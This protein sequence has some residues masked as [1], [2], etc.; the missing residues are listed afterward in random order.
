MS[1]TT[2]LNSGLSS[3]LKTGISQIL[4]NPQ[5][6]AVPELL[7]PY[8]S[9]PQKKLEEELAKIDSRFDLY[10]TNA[11]NLPKSVDY[12]ELSYTPLTDDEIKKYAE[13]ALKEYR[14]SGASQIND[15]AA[16]SRADLTSSKAGLSDA[17]L[18]KQQE[19]D[20]AYD[21]A[22]QS[23]SSDALKRGLARSSIIVNKLNALE[24]S[25]AGAKADAAES[26]IDGLY[27]IDQKIADLETERLD[28][29][30]EFDVLYA[31]KLSTEIQKQKEERRERLDEVIKYNNNLKTQNADY[32]LDYAK[33]DSAL[34][35]G[36][37]EKN[38]EIAEKELVVKMQ[39][40][41]YAEKYAAVSDH[42][43][44]MAAADAVKDL[45]NKKSFYQEQLGKSGYDKMLAEQKSRK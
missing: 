21:A 42:L 14:L 43:Y 45:E 10:G 34:D 31:A 44:N 33:T 25:K 24:A 29:L 22:K 26:L 7:G 20:S 28:A 39:Q 18:K 4:L 19:I 17:A 5:K 23:S 2:K 40:Q 16:R 35:S 11:Y 6:A 12:T 37:F 36:L 32:G 1:I 13:D 9:T 3:G 38:A 30:D 8:A 15:S 27:A 41:I